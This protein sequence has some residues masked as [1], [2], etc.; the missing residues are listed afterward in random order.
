MVFSE[1]PVFQV[2]LTLI[3]PHTTLLCI[4]DWAKVST[5]TSNRIHPFLSLPSTVLSP[6]VAMNKNDKFLPLWSFDM[7]VG[8][9]EDRNKTTNKYS[10]IDTHTALGLEFQMLR[11]TQGEPGRLRDYFS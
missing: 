11:S 5:Y 7:L 2:F 6:V 4:F 10:H 3:P 9:W 1:L 8:M